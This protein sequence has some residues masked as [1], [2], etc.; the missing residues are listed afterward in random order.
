MRGSLPSEIE[1]ELAAIVHEIV[2]GEHSEMRKARASSE[3]SVRS[4]K[5]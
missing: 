1:T 3:F 2:P 5:T 4:K